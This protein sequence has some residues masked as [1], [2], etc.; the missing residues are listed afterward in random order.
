MEHEVAIRESAVERYLFG[1]LS[2]AERDEFEEHFFECSECAADVRAGAAFLANA[3]AVWAEQSKSAVPAA[4]KPAPARFGWVDW[5]RASY[6]VPALAALL[7]VAGVRTVQLQSQLARVRMP[8]EPVMVVLRGETRGTPVTVT[9]QRGRPLLLAVDF[10]NPSGAPRLE[11]ELRNDAGAKLAGS[12]VEASRPGAPFYY[13][14][15]DA[16]LVPGRYNLGVRGVSPSGQAG[17]QSGSFT[18]EVH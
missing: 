16:H 17:A 9:Q 13:L 3:R 18:F 4:A 2:A 14:I 11:V 1:E 5:L 7:V 10:D 8:D 6:A 15:P 12:V